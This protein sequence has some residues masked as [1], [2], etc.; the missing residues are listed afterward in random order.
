MQNNDEFRFGFVDIG[1]EDVA[2]AATRVVERPSR[3]DKKGVKNVDV[4]N[5]C[6]KLIIFVNAGGGAA[7]TTGAGPYQSWERQWQAMFGEQYIY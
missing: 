2:V 1:L 5:T 6:A 3:R 7:D 4:Y